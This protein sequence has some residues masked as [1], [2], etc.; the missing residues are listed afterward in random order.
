MEK[1]DEEA[2]ERFGP[3]SGA[4]QRAFGEELVRMKG[5][6]TARDGVPPTQIYQTPEAWL[7][8]INGF[9]T[10]LGRDPDSEIVSALEDALSDEASAA[11]QGRPA[12]W[13]DELFALVG[14]MV[15]R[16]RGEAD[17]V[18]LADYVARSV[19][20]LGDD[21]VSV[22][23]W[24]FDQVGHSQDELYLPHFIGL[25]PHAFG[26]N[27]VPVTS[28]G[29]A[30]A[31]FRDTLF[32]DITE[33]ALVD[34]AILASTTDFTFNEGIRTGIALVVHADSRQLEAALVEWH[35]ADVA[36]VNADG[37]V[38]AT[39]ETGADLHEL[40]GGEVLKVDRAGWIGTP[41][42]FGAFRKPGGWV[43]NT[44]RFHFPGS[45]GFEQ[46]ASSLIVRPWIWS[47]PAEHDFWALGPEDADAC[48]VISAR[49]SV[50]GAIEGNLLY[51]DAHGQPQHRL[52]RLLLAG[53]PG[54][55]SQCVGS[56]IADC[57]HLDG[58]AR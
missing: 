24:P 14:P 29:F 44:V 2:K 1:L 27:Y 28:R 46:L 40:V 3:R 50:A 43:A 56:L 57:S 16:L 41:D 39:R 42:S 18:E 21:G 48:P 55:E 15:D 8:V 51:A 13:L 52:D 34:P 36:L 38:I 19:L 58:E 33:L 30:M 54:C 45:K 9:A 17:L 37:K 26:L 49:H 53:V 12:G 6:F 35:H 4:M 11:T 7:R 10:V 31:D 22:S 23:E 5:R 20:I 25:V 32:S 47:D